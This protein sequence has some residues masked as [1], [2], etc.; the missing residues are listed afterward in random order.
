MNRSGLFAQLLGSLD[1][2]G[3][4]TFFRL[5]VTDIQEHILENKLFEVCLQNWYTFW[6]HGSLITVEA[7]VPLQQCYLYLIDTVLY[8]ALNQFSC[9]LL[10][11]K[12]LFCLLTRPIKV[13]GLYCVSPWYFNWSFHLLEYLVEPLL[14]TVA[15]SAPLEVQQILSLS[16]SYLVAYVMRRRQR[17][18]LYSKTSALRTVFPNTSPSTSDRQIALTELS[19]IT[20]LTCTSKY[21]LTRRDRTKEQNFQHGGGGG[22]A[23]RD[24]P[25]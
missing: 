9:V 13:Y 23:G 18:E 25:H 21:Y 4:R 3:Y 12:S 16:D 20:S 5:V 7:R 2:G 17:S 1:Y 14:L 15:K 24:L 6:E 11:H 8:C 19:D 22:L 10:F